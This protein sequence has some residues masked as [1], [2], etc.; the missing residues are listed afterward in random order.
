M[1]SV[2]FAGGT[3]PGL[4]IRADLARIGVGTAPGSAQFSV[5]LSQCGIE[6]LRPDRLG[7]ELPAPQLPTR[8]SQLI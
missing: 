3:A 5:P 4:P 8:I 1:D 2:C 7:A 6:Q